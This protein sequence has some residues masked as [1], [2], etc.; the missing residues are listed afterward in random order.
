MRPFGVLLVTGRLEGGGCNEDGSRVCVIGED[1]RS[2]KWDAS[3]Q[4]WICGTWDVVIRC[5]SGVASG[6]KVMCWGDYQ[7][8]SDRCVWWFVEQMPWLQ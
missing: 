5:C 1:V 6:L 8:C 3:F 4:I 7:N 2:W